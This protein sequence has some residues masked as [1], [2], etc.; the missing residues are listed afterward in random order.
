MVKEILGICGVTIT[1]RL[2]SN[3]CITISFSCFS[4][5]SEKVIEL[6]ENIGLTTWYGDVFVT[7]CDLCKSANLKGKED[8]TETVHSRLI[9]V[10]EKVASFAYHH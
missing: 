5:I 6:L 3:N 8:V 2:E 10:Q 7:T 9:L 1:S 4:D